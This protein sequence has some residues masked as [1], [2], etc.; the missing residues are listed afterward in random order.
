MFELQG[1][2]P[3]LNWIV[4]PLL[5]IIPI[6]LIGV[7]FVLG[8]LPGKIAAARGHRRATAVRVC[9]WLGLITIVLWPVA[10][11]WAYMDPPD[12]EMRPATLSPDDIV[13]IANGLR[14]TSDRVAKIERLIAENQRTLG[15]SQ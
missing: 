3:A 1:V 13:H 7:L 8:G 11:I 10:L 4:L 14:Q 9:G 12:P 2:G 15:Q 5:F 6:L